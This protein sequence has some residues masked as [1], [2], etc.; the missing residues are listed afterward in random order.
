MKIVHVEDDA[1]TR[2]VVKDILTGAGHK[3][4][5]IGLP[6]KAAAAIK[7][8]KPKIVLLDIM[9]PGMSGWDVYKEIR[10]Y[11][12]KVHVAFLSVI[13][14]SKEREKTLAKEGVC[15]YIMKPFTAT[16]LVNIVEKIDG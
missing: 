1:D 11:D 5:S 6:K 10:K 7:K 8:E 3:V 4:T 13:E 12:K 9:M 16:E 15:A 2:A 14:V